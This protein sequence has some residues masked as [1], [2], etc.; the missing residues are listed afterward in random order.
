MTNREEAEESRLSLPFRSHSHS[1]RRAATMALVSLLL[2]L[3]QSFSLEG[4]DIVIATP[5]LVGLDCLGTAIA[6]IYE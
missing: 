6:P 3:Q 2:S 4:V 1:C 5:L